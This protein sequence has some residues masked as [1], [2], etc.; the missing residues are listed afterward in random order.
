MAKRYTKITNKLQSFIEQ[1]HMFFVGT[2]APEGRVNVSPKGMDSLRVLGP[3][4]VVW[5]NLTGSGNETAAHLQES[6]RMT[7]M[8]CAFEGKPMILR[9]YGQARVIYPGQD[10]WDSTIAL[11]P[12][13]VGVRQ[14][15]EMDIDLAL[16]SCGHAVPL[17]DYVADRDLLVK[18]AK[19]KGEAGL[20]AYRDKV[21]RVSLDGKPIYSPE[22][23]AE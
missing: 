1:Q 16:T 15:I 11:F 23:E 18:T 22:N 19:K 20:K 13:F 6:A 3:N 17:Y 12:P 5:L 7:L 4:K 21:N 14:V 2:A 8:F 10:A 9:L